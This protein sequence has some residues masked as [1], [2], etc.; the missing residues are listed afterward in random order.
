MKGLKVELKMAGVTVFGN[1]SKKDSCVLVLPDIQASLPGVNSAMVAG[2]LLERVY[3]K[4]P[5]LQ[6]A[7]VGGCVGGWVWVWVWGGGG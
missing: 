4:W 5:Y 6:E 3:I 2:M 1:P 7:Q